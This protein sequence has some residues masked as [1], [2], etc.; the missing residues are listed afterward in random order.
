M[1]KPRRQNR[2]DDKVTLFEEII[3]RKVIALDFASLRSETTILAADQKDKIIDINF[4]ELPL[5]IA[6]VSA[7][8]KR[9]LEFSKSVLLVEDDLTTDSDGDKYEAVLDESILRQATPL[10]LSTI[11]GT[12]NPG[13]LT[14]ARGVRIGILDSGIDTRYPDLAA[15]IY[16]G[17]SFVADEP[18]PYDDP[19]GHGTHCACIAASAG[20]GSG[21]FGV[22]PGASIYSIKVMNSSRSVTTSRAVLGLLKAYFSGCHIASMSFGFSDKSNVLNAVCDFVAD[23]GLVAIASAGNNVSNVLFPAAFDSVIGV[24][25]AR[26]DGAGAIW[27]LFQDDGVNVAA[28]GENIPAFGPYPLI[29]PWTGSSAAC[30]FVAGAAAMALSTHR[31]G[32]APLQTSLAI[33]LLLQAYAVHPAGRSVRDR[34]LGFGIVDPYESTAA[35]DIKPRWRLPV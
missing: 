21:V 12:K 34:Q 1:E 29:G 28:P 4:F 27:P 10:L 14:T 8:E 6:K 32:L 18:N 19:R 9:A 17:I 20:V 30:A 7:K 33:R 35:F 24:A 2:T 16:G 23:K 5:I 26:S 15:N 31:F 22:A 25:A 13:E 11:L 3:G